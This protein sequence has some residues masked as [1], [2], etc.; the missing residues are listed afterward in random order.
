MTITTVLDQVTFAPYWPDEI[1]FLEFIVQVAKN[2]G[3]IIVEDD[4]QRKTLLVP[5]PKTRKD[6]Q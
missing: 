3:K 2:G 4:E 6:N 1:E 5:K